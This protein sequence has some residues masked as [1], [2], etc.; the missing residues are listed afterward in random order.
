MTVTATELKLN[1]GKYLELASGQDIYISKNGKK[2]ALLTRPDIDK[3]KVLDSLVGI[4]PDSS[5]I[6]DIKEERLLK[7]C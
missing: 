3:I 6:S 1:L 7:Q 4:I 5:D 2:I